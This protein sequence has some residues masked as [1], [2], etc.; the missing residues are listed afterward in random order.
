MKDDNLNELVVQPDAKAPNGESVVGKNIIKYRKLNGISQKHLA[1]AIGVS[2]QGLLK[3]EKGKVSPRTKTLEKIIDVL[4]ITPNQ[5]FGV[6]QITE[7]NSSIL[8][9]LRKMQG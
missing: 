5:L 6:D 7:D 1:S 3:I 9:R 2:S 8:T 4:C